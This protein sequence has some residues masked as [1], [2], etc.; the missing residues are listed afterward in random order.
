[1]SIKM[2]T[3][4]INEIKKLMLQTKAG[5]LSSSFGSLEILYALYTSININQKNLSDLQSRDMVIISKEHCRLAQVCTLAYL[6]LLNKDL[7]KTYMQDGG[8]LGHDLY[9]FVGDKEIAAVDYGSGSLG[10]GVGVS[11]GLALANKNRNIYVLIGDGELQ[12]GSLWEGFFYILQNNICNITVIADRN[13]MQIDNY[14]KNIIDTS[15]N[16]KNIMSTIG[17]DVLTCDGH[18]ISD[19]QKAINKKCAKPKFIIADTIKGKGMEFLLEELGF[20]MFHHSRLTN[21]NLERV[22]EK[23][24]GRK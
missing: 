2:N 16:M 8:K 10:H 13:Y 5:H 3:K 15:S 9:N 22:W 20:A 24:N 7:I 17:F 21:E 23:I 1:M 18:N 11:I 19:I 12:E 14:T 4:D 6:G